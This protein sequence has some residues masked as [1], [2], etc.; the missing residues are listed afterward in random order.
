MNATAP[1]SAELLSLL[2]YFVALLGVVGIM[3]GASYLLGQRHTGRHTNDPFESGIKSTGT[4][5]MRFSAKFYIVG[6][7]FVI[8]DLEV[9][10]IVAWAVAVREV[11]WTGYFGLL[12][13]IVIL[14][15]GLIYEWRVGAIDWIGEEFRT[16]RRTGE[17]A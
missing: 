16:L 12:A 11:G 6:L 4:A 1:E 10:F 3:L 17:K 15:T 5:R 2:V 7:L 8:F 14:I 13:F 9:A